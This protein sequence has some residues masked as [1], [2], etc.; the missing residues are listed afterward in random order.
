[1]TS[2]P[3]TRAFVPG[4]PCS[5]PASRPGCRASST[6]AV[7]EHDLFR[8]PPA[9]SEATQLGLLVGIA[10]NQTAQAERLQRA[11]PAG[12]LHRHVGRLGSRETAPRVL[13]SDHRRVR[14]PL[15]VD[16]GCRGPAGVGQVGLRALLW[17][18]AGPKRPAWS[19]P[20]QPGGRHRIVRWL[21][22]AR[23][24]RQ[25]PH[26]DRQTRRCPPPDIPRT[27]GCRSS[28]PKAGM[29]CRHLAAW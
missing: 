17:K 26:R 9:P 10:S 22:I 4:Q 7:D 21:D 18:A 23:S 20:G 29:G 1:V 12:R 8:T 19:P 24:L 2:G 28:G 3:R 15:V 11:E 14:V 13:R 5:T 16:G 25:P 6:P 27:L